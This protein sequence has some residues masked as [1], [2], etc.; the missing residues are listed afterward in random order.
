MANT[1][2]KIAKLIKIINR[3]L[4][5]LETRQNIKPTDLEDWA[6]ICE[7]SRS[8]EIA[9]QASIDLGNRMIAMYGFSTVERYAE[10]AKELHRQSVIG[11]KLSES[12]V[13]IFKFRNVLVHMY[14]D[15]DLQQFL[16]HFRKDPNTIQRFAR[17]VLLFLEKRP[18]P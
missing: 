10:I 6:T 2:G 1:N 16:R 14:D 4:K 7:V 11:A 15:L 3:A 13:D 17:S 5:H 9:I 8:L 18:L 12:L